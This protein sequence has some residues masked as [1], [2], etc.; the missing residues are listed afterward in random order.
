MFISAQTVSHNQDS[1]LGNETGE[2][3]DSAN[4]YSDHNKYRRDEEGLRKILSSTSCIW[5][6]FFVFFVLIITLFG[7]VA[8]IHGSDSFSTYTTSGPNS[9]VAQ[10]KAFGSIT[11][12]NVGGSL[13]PSAQ[14]GLGNELQ[15]GAGI[16]AYSTSFGSMQCPEYLNLFSLLQNDFMLTYENLGSL[17]TYEIFNVPPSTPDSPSLTSEVVGNYVIYQAITLD[18]TSGVF[19]FVP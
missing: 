17:G 1:L 15:A 5:G 13:I 12:T 11:Q 9:I 7:L 4:V 19:V 16:T 10:Y 8:D 6:C 3:Q 14:P 18:Q 2:R